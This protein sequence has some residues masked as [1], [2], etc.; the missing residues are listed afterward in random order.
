MVCYV[1]N[2]CGLGGRGATIH[3]A[4]CAWAMPYRVG[5]KW[6]GRFVGSYARPGRRGDDRLS[7]EQTAA[8]AGLG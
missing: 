3:R 1:V 6:L 5:E 2:R 4:D 7:G 8:T